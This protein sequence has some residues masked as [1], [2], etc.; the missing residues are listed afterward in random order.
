MPAFVT[1]PEPPVRKT[2]N[3]LPDDGPAGKVR[4]AAAALEIDAGAGCRA[5]AAGI[6]ERRGTSLRKDAVDLARDR[7]GG[8]IRDAAAGLQT[9]TVRARDAA[10]VAQRREQHRW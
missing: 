1:V 3:V 7:G 2:P 10:A 8:G 4:D 6:A 5:D 9:D